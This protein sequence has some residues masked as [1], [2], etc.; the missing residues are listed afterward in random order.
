M[1]NFVITGTLKWI[2]PKGIEVEGNTQASVYVEPDGLKS[3]KIFFI[4]PNKRNSGEYKC[5]YQQVFNH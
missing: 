1:I 5:Q 4:N 3:L 2:N